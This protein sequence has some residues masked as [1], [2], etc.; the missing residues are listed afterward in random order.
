MRDVVVG[1]LGLVV[2]V[3][4]VMATLATDFFRQRQA[5]VADPTDPVAPRV[6]GGRVFWL[7]VA[8]VV[9]TVMAAAATV[10]RLATLA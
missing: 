4:A 6:P 8:S 5:P 7:T 2:V 10:V 3:L 1:W 9:L